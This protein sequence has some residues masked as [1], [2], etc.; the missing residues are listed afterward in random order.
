[1]TLTATQSEILAFWKTVQKEL[2]EIQPNYTLTSLPALDEQIEVFALQFT[3]LYQ[4][5]IHGLYLRP[6]TDK[7][8]PV[9]IESLGYWNKIEDPFQF[10]HWPQM[11]YACLV[12]DN[13]AQGGKTL[14]QAPYH[15]TS[16]PEPF[17]RGIL[18]H[19]DFYF[20]RLLADQLRLVHFATT[21]EELDQTQI[22]FRGASQGGGV[23]LLLG[24]LLPN[25]PKWIFADVP[26]HSNIKHRVSEKTGSY[27]VIGRFLDYYPH[28]Q[29][30]IEHELSY[31]DLQYLADLITCPV[32]ISV[33]S[34]DPVCPMKDFIP[35]YHK[36]TAPKTLRVYWKKGHEGGAMAQTV[37]EINQ[38]NQITQE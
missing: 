11:G 31:F 12:I 35:A 14:D 37:R 13:R 30:Q 8:V 28:Q 17:G 22:I 29:T 21:R 10:S 2:A 38:I 33:A 34:H 27:G 1:M 18:E 24:A 25:I 7:V 19:E 3:S 6:K 16:H 5:V 26:S 36:I 32:S 23:V 15:T 20:K 9:I 4:E